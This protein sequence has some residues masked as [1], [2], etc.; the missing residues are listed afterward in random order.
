MSTAGATAEEGN[1]ETIIP[2]LPSLP[3]ELLGHVATALPRDDRLAFSLAARSLNEARATAKL[4]L[5]TKAKALMYSGS[6]ALLIWAKS[7]GCPLPRAKPRLPGRHAGPCPFVNEVFDSMHLMRGR[8]DPMN[9]EDDD[10]EF[11]L[12]LEPFTQEQLEC[13]AWPESLIALTNEHAEYAKEQGEADEEDGPWETI[14][15][16]PNG[17]YFTVSDLVHAI[18]DLEYEED[19]DEGQLTRRA[20]VYCA[21]RIGTVHSRRPCTYRGSSVAHT[22][23]IYFEGLEYTG[24]IVLDQLDDQFPHM[25]SVQVFMPLYG[26]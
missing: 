22:G 25:K 3:I 1:N 8:T 17:S 4:K 5:K 16:A 12:E 14:V 19:C 18:A 7:I 20:V 10:L 24:E 2:S 26:S 11:N 15:E 13:V 23:H 9:M 6:E 21:Y